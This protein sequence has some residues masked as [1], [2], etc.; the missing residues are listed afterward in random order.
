ML[1]LQ[2]YFMERQAAMLNEQESSRSEGAVYKFLKFRGQC[3]KWTVLW[4][5]AYSKVVHSEVLLNGANPYGQVQVG[6]I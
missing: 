6:A 5:L 3:E 1:E 4:M 2:L